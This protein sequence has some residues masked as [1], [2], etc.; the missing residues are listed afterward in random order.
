MPLPRNSFANN[1]AEQLQAAIQKG[2][3]PIFQLVLLLVLKFHDSADRFT[4]VH[5]IKTMIY[6][7]QGQLVGDHRINLDLAVHVPIHDLW[8]IRTTRR[9]AERRPAP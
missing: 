1:F 4:F 8:N 9:S 6:L 2:C 5:Q 7:V 3:S